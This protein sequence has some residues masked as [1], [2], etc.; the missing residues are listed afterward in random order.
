MALTPLPP[1]ERRAVVDRAWNL[2]DV[3][4]VPFLIEIG[5]FHAATARYYDS[6]EAEL[7]WDFIYLARRLEY[8]TPEARVFLQPVLERVVV[9][10]TAAAASAMTSLTPCHTRSGSS[11]IQP[12]CG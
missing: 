11:S 10:D 9:R 4:E 3:E 2:L 7:E 12:A 8:G 6:G 1:T 5:G